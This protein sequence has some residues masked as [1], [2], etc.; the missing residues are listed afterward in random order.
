MY[1]ATS[2]CNAADLIEQRPA[3]SIDPARRV[4]LDCFLD[5]LEHGRTFPNRRANDGLDQNCLSSRFLGK[6]RPSRNRSKD[7][8]HCARYI[9]RYNVIVPVRETKSFLAAAHIEAGSEVTEPGATMVSHRR[10]SRMRHLQ[11]VN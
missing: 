10:R 6:V 3:D 5:Y 2:A 1:A 8:D 7:S 11:R 4:G 9:R